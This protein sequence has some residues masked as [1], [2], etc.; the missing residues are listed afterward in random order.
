[1][2]NGLSS[3][4]DQLFQGRPLST[5]VRFGT[6]RN[7]GRPRH[8]LTFTVHNLFDSAPPTADEDNGFVVGTVNPR[9]RQ[10]R[11]RYSFGF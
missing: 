5:T 9:G 8:M 3:E 7:G 10:F 4:L 2:P 6:A 11:L 1:M